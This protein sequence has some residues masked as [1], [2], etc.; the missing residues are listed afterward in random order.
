M[1]HRL[2]NVAGSGPR[3]RRRLLR[4]LPAL[5]ALAVMPLAACDTRELLQ[6][7]DIDVVRPDAITGREGL[8]V[9]YA[10]AVE[11]FGNAY[12]GT[13]DGQVSTSAQLADEFVN[14]ETFPTRIE[15]DQRIM[16]VENGTLTAVFRDLARARAAA[17]RAASAF[18]Q[19]DSKSVNFA[20]VLS[21]SGLAYVIFAENYCSGVPFVQIKPDG[22]FDPVAG[23]TTAQM[24][25][26]AV[27]KFDS[28]LT[29]A[30]SAGATGAAQV[31]LAKVGKGRALLNLGQ[32]AAAAAAVGPATTPV[33]TPAVPVAFQYQYQHSETTGRQNNATWALTVSVARFGVG[34]PDTLVVLPTLTGEG[35][36]GTPFRVGK[37]GTQAQVTLDPR[38]PIVQR[39]PVS[40]PL[41]RGFDGTTI[42]YMQQKYPLRASPITIADGTEASLIRAEALLSAG[43]AQGALDTL[44]ALRASAVARSQRMVTAT[45]APL[46]LQ[47]TPAARVDQLF[48][49]RAYWLFLTSHRLGDLRRLTRPSPGGYGR[50][51]ETVYPTGPYH[52]GG[53]YGTD[54]NIPVPQSEENN[55]AF[56]RSACN[57]M[58]P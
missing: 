44:N 35:I 43:N 17:D 47:A 37:S 9:L 46:T 53:T 12:N 23:L 15:I 55:P 8:P 14:T 54:V 36:N 42:Q 4:R 41:S 56:V 22:S 51:I 1:I 26:R 18:R 19:F 7:D 10:G 38:A 57:M 30:A 48:R 52:K 28:A 58:T 3:S 33:A 20:E 50:G 29:I 27:T 6:V 21:L 31:N 11:N 24:L 2:T 25:A 39:N 45:L 16:K 49:E 5:V 13:S 34:N 40:L 32:F